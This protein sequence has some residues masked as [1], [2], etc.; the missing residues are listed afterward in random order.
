[1]DSVL[2]AAKAAVAPVAQPKAKVPLWLWKALAIFPLT[3]L[4]GV[5]YYSAGSVESAVAKFLVNLVTLGAWYFH[6]A[7]YAFDGNKVMTEGLKFPFLET[8]SLNPG[9]V[10][11]EAPFDTN[12][13]TLLFILLTGF[14]ALIYGIAWFFGETN[15]VVGDVSK[16]M[17]TI[18][19]AATGALGTFTGYTVYIQAQAAA[20]SKAASAIPGGTQITNLAK[21]A[22]LMKGGAKSEAVVTGDFFALGTLFV[23]AFAGF[24]LSSVRSKSLV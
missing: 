3:G 6:D 10:S 18:S 9:V 13:K 14:S 24:A 2:S 11:S 4:L 21:T 12:A 7:L 1:M 22:G 8:V 23:V 15:G 19:G 20:I 5:D 16:A 17:K